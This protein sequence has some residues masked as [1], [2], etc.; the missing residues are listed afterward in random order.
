[1]ATVP[2]GPLSGRALEIVCATG[3]TVYD[4]LYVASAEVRGDRL[5][6]ADERL[7]R[8]LSGSEWEDRVRRVA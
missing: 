2:A 4:A 1:M 8:L 5:W 6:T 7:M 3:A